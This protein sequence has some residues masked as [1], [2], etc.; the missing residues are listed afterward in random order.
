MS[1]SGQGHARA[2]LRVLWGVLLL[3]W[4]VALAK[5]VVGT[6]ANNLT[7]VADGYHSLL[8]GA[9]NVVGIVAMHVASKP[10]DEDHPYGHRKFEHLAAMAIGALVMLLCWE[11]AKGAIQQFM[12][13]RE[14]MEIPRHFSPI[15]VAVV[16]GTLGING[17]VAWWERRA[18]ERLCSPLLKAD[19]THTASDAAVTSLGLLSLLFGARAWWIDPMLALVVVVFLVR[20]AWGIIADNLATMTDRSRIDPA[21][22]RDVAEGVPGVLNAHSIRSHGMENDIHVDLHIVV[23]EELSAKAVAELEDRVR[24]ALRAAFPGVTLIAIEHQTEHEERESLWH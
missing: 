14:G 9:N 2:V 6:L 12:A 23:H 7:V 17:L 8:D 24:V 1:A 18:G 5:I 19:A 16:L 3:N 22:I 4:L 21:L 20:A 13:A 15:M 11:T 10:P